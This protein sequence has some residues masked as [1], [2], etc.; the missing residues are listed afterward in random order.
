MEQ[1]EVIGLAGFIATVVVSTLAVAY[2]QNQQRDKIHARIDTTTAETKK[3]HKQLEQQFNDE[4]VRI[5][6]EHPDHNHL[7]EHVMAPMQAG[8]ERIE[9]LVKEAL[10]K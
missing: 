6:K 1:S 9:T 8:F 3:Q 5:A 4:R 10:K 2:R 7:K